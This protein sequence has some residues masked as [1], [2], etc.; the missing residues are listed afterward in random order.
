MWLT[1]LYENVFD[2]V[3]ISDVARVSATRG[4]PWIWRPLKEQM[5]QIDY[6]RPRA[7]ILKPTN[8]LL[9]IFPIFFADLFLGISIFPILCYVYVCIIYKVRM[10]L[11]AF[12]VV[13]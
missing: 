9:F 4:R 10:C 3:Y 6:S 11:V 13:L 12:H 2:R 7:N 5:S 1:W 8:W